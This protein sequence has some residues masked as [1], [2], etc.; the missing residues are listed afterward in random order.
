[1]ATPGHDASRIDQLA[2]LLAASPPRHVPDDL[3]KFALRRTAPLLPAIMGVFFIL[4]GVV[5]A[6]LMFPRHILDEHRIDAADAARTAGEI[7]AVEPT[8]TRI[9]ETPVVRYRFRYTP[10][11]AAPEHAF[12]HEGVCYTTGE[13]WS[14]GD[15]VEVRYLPDRPQL[16]RPAEA[17]LSE[18]GWI[19]LIVLLFPLVGIALTTHVVRSRRRAARILRHGVL[20]EAR[21]IAIDP[22]SRYVQRQRIHRIT[23]QRTDLPAERA[24]HLSRHQADQIARARRHLE[25]KQPVYLLVDP[26]SPKHVLLPEWW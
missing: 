24:L 14:V 10:D 23:L 15:R 21:V 8:N 5:P 6:W 16:A 3:R 11:R 22:T 4:V 20:A 26:Q 19:G 2:A 18:S 13:R 25:S 9:N 12:E 7:V 17:R 1:M